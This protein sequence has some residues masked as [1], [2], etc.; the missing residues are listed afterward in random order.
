LK[1]YTIMIFASVLVFTVLARTG[2]PADSNSRET[3]ELLCAPSMRTPIEEMRAIFEKQTGVSTQIS[4]EPTNVIL[5]QLR[6]HP[7]GDLFVA[8]DRFYIRAAKFGLVE[9][10]HICTYLVPVIMI[11]KGNP[12]NIYKLSDLTNYKVTVGLVDERTGAMGD[13]AAEVLKKN[14]IS[15]NKVNVMYRATT[16]DELANAI[17]LN[18]VD[19]VIIW[20]PIAMLYTKYGDIIDIPNDRNIILTVS[21][22]IISTSHKRPIARKFLKFI[23]SKK[24]KSIFSKYYYPTIN[25]KKGTD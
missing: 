25:P 18:T 12:H 1:H 4:F 8:A 19:A 14:H 6:L 9:E 24:G 16:V 7:H 3:L 17:R 13:V 5:E 20:K 2:C 21:A 22:G 10:L 23:M 11:Q 15:I